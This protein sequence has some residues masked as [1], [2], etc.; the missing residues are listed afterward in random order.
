MPSLIDHNRRSDPGLL[1]VRPV[2][3][4]NAGSTGRAANDV[5]WRKLYEL[6]GIADEHFVDTTV[7]GERIRAY[8]KFRPRRRT[9]GGR[10]VSRVVDG[11]HENSPRG[12]LL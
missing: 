7:D 5:Y 4:K 2:D 9:S 1:P 3:M 6:C 11:F 10:A 12:T 8:F